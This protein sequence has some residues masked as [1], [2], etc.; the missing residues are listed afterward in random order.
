MNKTKKKNSITKIFYDR[1]AIKNIKS[2]LTFKDLFCLCYSGSLFPK[3]VSKM[4]QIFGDIWCETDPFKFF[5][6]SE[7]EDMMVKRYTLSLT[8][9]EKEYIDIFL[10]E[11]I[12]VKGFGD[13]YKYLYEIEQG[14]IGDY[15]ALSHEDYALSH[16][17][18]ALSRAVLLRQVPIVKM[19][20]EK[21]AD[22]KRVDSKNRTLL[23][24]AARKGYQEIVQLLIQYGCNVRTRDLWGFTAA[25]MARLAGHFEL[26]QKIKWSYVQKE[27]EEPLLNTC[28]LSKSGYRRIHWAI[29]RG[30]SYIVE[31]LI[32]Q[33]EDKD[34]KARY[35]ETPLHLAAERGHTEI[36]KLLLHAGANK[37]AKNR[38]RQTPLHLAA[39]RGHTEIV[40]L[41]LHAGAMK[42]EDDM[43]WNTPL[44]IAAEKGHTDIRYLLEYF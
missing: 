1:I 44:N 15:H 5:N 23:H 4:K 24:F 11:I 36:V 43:Y 27:I 18:Y 41:L 31:K 39:E 13:R 20:L 2:F 40:K 28:Y 26:C 25:K 38:Y 35:G 30:F 17:D 37:D 33:G 22:A 29:K 16:E 6:N 9:I 21:G 14:I 32:E 34:A 7:V 10:N 3:L 19:L 12:S 8:P 42:N